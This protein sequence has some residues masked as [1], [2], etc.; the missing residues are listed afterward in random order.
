MGRVFFL[1]SHTIPSTNTKQDII[2][3]VF[4]LF[5]H[6]AERSVVDCFRNRPRSVHA[7]HG[8]RAA[9][10][11]ASRLDAR[12]VHARHGGRAASRPSTLPTRIPA[13]RRSSSTSPR[14]SNKAG[15]VIYAPALRSVWFGGKQYWVF[16]IGNCPT[17]RGGMGANLSKLFLGI[18]AAGKWLLYY[19]RALRSTSSS[20]TT[21]SSTSSA[22]ANSLGFTGPP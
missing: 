6:I 18:K 8:G 2:S 17:K 3:I 14:T 1:D 5:H 10:L 15:V 12:S 20:S 21:P 4:T 13:R 22:L 16:V 9:N 7:R 11:A 19:C